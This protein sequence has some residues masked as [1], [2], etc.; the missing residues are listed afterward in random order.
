MAN[1]V[2]KKLLNI[3]KTFAVPEAL[4]ACRGASHSEPEDGSLDGSALA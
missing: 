1:Q 4:V 3:Y 2:L